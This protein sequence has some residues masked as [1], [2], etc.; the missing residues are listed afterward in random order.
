MSPERPPLNTSDGGQTIIDV[1]A[2]PLAV[3][4]TTILSHIPI[5]ETGRGL[6]LQTNQQLFSHNNMTAF[7]TTSPANPA[8][9][10]SKLLV[11][12]QQQPTSAHMNNGT[13]SAHV[14]MESFIAGKAEII[15]VKET[16]MF[17]SF[18]SCFS[19]NK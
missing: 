6:I 3:P 14:P 17:F 15:I 16:I 7:A 18:F 9:P 4:N 2:I 12:Q 5:I 8:T 11:L 13:N 10:S 1:N 19:M